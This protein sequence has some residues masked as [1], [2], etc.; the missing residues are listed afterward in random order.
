MKKVR[1][2]YSDALGDLINLD[3]GPK[4]AA[5]PAA[6]PAPVAARAAPPPPPPK[7]KVSA[8]ELARAAAAKKK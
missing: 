6:V 1:E 2:S 4:G 3:F 5:K 8:A 7:P